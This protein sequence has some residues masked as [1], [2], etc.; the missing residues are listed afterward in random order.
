VSFE[1]PDL[2]PGGRRVRVNADY[3]GEKL[4]GIADDEDLAK[5]IL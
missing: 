5:Y 3:V 4:R 2:P 1:A